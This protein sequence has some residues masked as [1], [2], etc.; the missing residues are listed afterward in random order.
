M[1][2]APDSD[3]LNISPR[4][5]PGFEC[6]PGFEKRNSSLSAESLRVA[7]SDLR[8]PGTGYPGRVTVAGIIRVIHHG[9]CHAVG[10][11]AAKRREPGSPRRPQPLTHHVD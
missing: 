2:L 9:G 1:R 8:L 6:G 11:P 10:V 5:R 3:S 4:A 7:G